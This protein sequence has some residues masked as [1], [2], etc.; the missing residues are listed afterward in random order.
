MV[1]QNKSSPLSDTASYDECGCGISYDDCDTRKARS[2]D[3][4][5]AERMRKSLEILL[6]LNEAAPNYLKPE[7]LIIEK[8]YNILSIKRLQEEDGSRIAIK[9]EHGWFIIPKH[10]SDKL[11]KS[12]RNV[13]DIVI[14]DNLYFR[15]GGLINGKARC[16]YYYDNKQGS[17]H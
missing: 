12:G 9:I 8:K 10:D 14:T 16:V 5:E 4:D 17:T 15:Y 7:D 6:I 3:E 13:S 11:V 2:Y 1:L